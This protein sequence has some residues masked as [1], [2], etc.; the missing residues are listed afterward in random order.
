MLRSTGHSGHTV[1]SSLLGCEDPVKSWEHLK[2]TYLFPASLPS[3]CPLCPLCPLKAPT[4]TFAGQCGVASTD[5][6]LFDQPHSIALD[7]KHNRLVFGTQ[8]PK[9]AVPSNSNLK[10][11]RTCLPSACPWCGSR[12]CA[13][14]QSRCIGVHTSLA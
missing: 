3:S 11:T 8:H 7:S 12:D 6:P 1:S 9:P 2:R 13:A 14:R 4:T 10:S 5:G